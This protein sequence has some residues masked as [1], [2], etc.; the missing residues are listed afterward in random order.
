MKPR[1]L[2]VE[3]QAI[4]ARA[5]RVMLERI[6]CEVT[7]VV[8]AGEKAILEAE[9]SALDLIL[10]D[11]RLRGEMTGVE[12]AAAINE[13]FGTPVIFVSAYPAHELK[14]SH[15]LDEDAKCLS[16]PLGEAELADA[17]REVLSGV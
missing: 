17:V 14:E 11:I 3:D 16:K 8:D 1:V 4:A 10:M 7:A 5:A 2:V 15:P 9:G 6:G 13:R 12:A